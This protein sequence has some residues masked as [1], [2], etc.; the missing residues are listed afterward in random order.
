V[1][2][3]SNLVAKL[4]PI[5]LDEHGLAVTQLPNCIFL[6]AACINRKKGTKLIYNWVSV[7]LDSKER[8]EG[9]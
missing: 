5:A 3:A 1:S 4:V 9:I 6:I 7:Y 8:E 2:H